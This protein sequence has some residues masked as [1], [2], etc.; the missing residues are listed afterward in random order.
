MVERELTAMKERNEER[1]KTIAIEADR[2]AA[3]EKELP[4]EVTR[5]L[6]SF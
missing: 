4:K 2:K 3:E 1:M 5:S 6:S